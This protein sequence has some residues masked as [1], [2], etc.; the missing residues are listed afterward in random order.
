MI[1][2]CTAPGAKLARTYHRRLHGTREAIIDPSTQLR[3]SRRKRML[4]DNGGGLAHSSEE[5][6]VMEVEPRGQHVQVSK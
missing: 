1:I 4:R 6:S 5:P 3:G 2:G